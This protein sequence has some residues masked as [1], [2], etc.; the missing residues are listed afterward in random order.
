MSRSAT[1]YRLQDIDSQIQYIH[2]RIVE[3]DNQL[4]DKKKLF[5]A[6]DKVL[7]VHDQ[8]SENQKILRTTENKVKDQ[9]LKIESTDKDLYSGKI[10]NPKELEDLQNE[11]AA[12]RRYLEILEDRQL[13]AM[14]ALEETEINYQAAEEELEKIKDNIQEL[15]FTLSN[16]LTN[17]NNDLERLQVEREAVIQTVG[18]EDQVIYDNLINSRRGL[19][20]VAIIDQTCGACGTTLTPATIQSAQSPSQIVQCQSCR[21]ILYPG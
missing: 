10:R 8:L 15:R 4:S 19:A 6:E 9:Q 2:S 11:S 20:V 14:I 7:K 16:E 5:D 21:R 3:I 12:L 1:L 17:L 13:E 18:K